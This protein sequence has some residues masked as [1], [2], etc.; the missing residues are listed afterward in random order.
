MIV[1]SQYIQCIRTEDQVTRC[2]LVVGC[3]DRAR[4]I[5]ALDDRCQRMGD[6]SL[7]AHGGIGQDL[8]IHRMACIEDQVGGFETERVGIGML[9]LLQYFVSNAPHKD[10]RMVTVA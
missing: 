10:G 4:L 7:Y 1:E 5:Q 8:V 9:P 2:R 6:Q 3:S